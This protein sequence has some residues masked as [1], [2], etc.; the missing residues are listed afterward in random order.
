MHP[1]LP[2][3]RC[4]CGA[5]VRARACTRPA[6][7]AAQATARSTTRST[8]T[9]SD[10]PAHDNAPRCPHCARRRVS[11]TSFP[12]CSTAR[13]GCV[14]LEATKWRN[15]FP[16]E[17]LTAADKAFHAVSRLGSMVLLLAQILTKL[18]T[19]R[20]KYAICVTWRPS[21]WPYAP[22]KKDWLTRSS[23]PM[24]QM[25]QRVGFPS[26]TS[27]ELETLGLFRSGLPVAAPDCTWG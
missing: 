10:G 11:R 20:T 27:H 16:H 1:H 14:M 9:S 7:G 8:G 21:P 13:P 6:A 5:R 24:V 15:R 25:H 26:V 3:G 19:S 4:I 18:I 22:L 12:P 2:K 17:P 23:L